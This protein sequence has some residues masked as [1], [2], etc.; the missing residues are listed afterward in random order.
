LVFSSVIVNG[1]H[2]CVAVDICDRRRHSVA[3]TRS[4]R[5]VVRGDFPL[6]CSRVLSN[7]LQYSNKNPVAYVSLAMRSD[8][9]F[10]VKIRWK[11]SLLISA[12]K[13]HGGNTV[14]LRLSNAPCC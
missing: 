6:D 12:A 11:H 9:N 14:D 2:G 13:T 3:R 4:R 5:Y 10:S 8:A 7:N 1:S